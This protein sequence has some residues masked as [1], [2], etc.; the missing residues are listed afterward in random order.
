MFILQEECFPSIFERVMALGVKG[1]N[2]RYF[3][4]AAPQ[5]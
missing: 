1:F 3:G 5:T 4:I 2:A